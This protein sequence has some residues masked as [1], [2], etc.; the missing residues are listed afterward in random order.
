MSGVEVCLGECLQVRCKALRVVLVAVPTRHREETTFHHHLLQQEEGPTGSQVQLDHL[1][2]EEQVPEAASHL[3]GRH[4][5]TRNE[6]HGLPSDVRPS[7]MHSW[8]RSIET[9]NMS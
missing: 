1:G 9:S 3:R 4:L 8:I 7:G 2:T 6:Q 5:R